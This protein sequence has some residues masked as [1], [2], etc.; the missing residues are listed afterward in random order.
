MRRAGKIQYQK[1]PA[2]SWTLVIQGWQSSLMI[3]VWFGLRY[4]L[5]HVVACGYEN[6]PKNE[7]LPVD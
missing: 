1:E 2:I 7:K 3:R 5:Q 4:N 6:A